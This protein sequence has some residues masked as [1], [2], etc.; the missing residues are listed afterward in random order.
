MTWPTPNFCFAALA[1]KGTEK[2]HC[3]TNSQR[4][5]KSKILQ[6]WSVMHLFD[7]YTQRFLNLIWYDFLGTSLLSKIF[8]SLA[9]HKFI[10][11]QVF[12]S[13]YQFP[14]ELS[15]L[16]Q[17]SVFFFHSI[18]DSN[19]PLKE[20]IFPS[21]CLSNICISLPSLFRIHI[22]PSKENDISFNFSVRYLHFPFIFF[23]ES[24]CISF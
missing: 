13:L 2:L 11:I 16:L 17:I 12:C 15:I 10:P 14:T 21:I 9:V 6:K 18:S 19:L 4:W 23:S 3:F 7:E 22:C 5:Q 24:A 8:T 20:M 1:V